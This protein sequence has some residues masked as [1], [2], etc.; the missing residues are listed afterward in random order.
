MAYLTS[1]IY[2]MGLLILSSTLP[3]CPI[4]RK[5]LIPCWYE[6][7]LLAWL[8]G[9]LLS[10]LTTPRDRGGQ[11]W[12]RTVMLVLSGSAV[13]IHAVTFLLPKDYWSLCFFARNQL[14]AVVLLF[15]CALLLDFLSF[16]YLFGP[17]A[18]IIGELMLPILHHFTSSS[19]I[20]FFAIFQEILWW[21][22]DVS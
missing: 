21:T 19:F 4:M 3:I 11:F 2:L 13:V 18:I 1:H 22:L 16:H 14:L 10:E 17:W 5:S 8:S 12:L 7:L 9:M 20:G 15:C 6:W